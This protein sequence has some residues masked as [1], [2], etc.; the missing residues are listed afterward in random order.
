MQRECGDGRRM[1]G[2]ALSW[3][4]PVPVVPPQPPG[5]FQRSAV[6]SWGCTI[7]MTATDPEEGVPA[8]MLTARVPSGTAA[9][10]VDSSRSV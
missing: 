5:G 9:I 2:V 10:C 7:A 6:D 8:S 3:Q 4:L 1:P